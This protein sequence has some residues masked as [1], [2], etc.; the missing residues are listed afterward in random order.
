MTI[1]VTITKNDVQAIIS[2]LE[3]MVE[4]LANMHKGEHMF[5]NNMF[6]TCTDNTLEDTDYDVC[7]R[8]GEYTVKCGVISSRFFVNSYIELEFHDYQTLFSEEF[9]LNSIEEIIEI[10]DILESI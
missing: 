6:I 10:S 1:N 3:G 9:P 7:D 4:T 8:C 5:T 2:T